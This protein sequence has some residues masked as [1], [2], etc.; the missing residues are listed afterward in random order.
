[1]DTNKY[2]YFTLIFIINIIIFFT[3]FKTKRC[4]TEEKNYYPI[5]FIGI[6]S[7]YGLVFL[8]PSHRDILYNIL[9]F[10]AKVVFA[11]FIGLT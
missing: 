6:W 1:M 10:I 7:L 8:L 3:I 11:F 5:I 9:D 2:L 4:K